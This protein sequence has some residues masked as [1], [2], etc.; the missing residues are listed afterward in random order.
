MTDDPASGRVFG[1]PYSFEV[2]TPR[3][4][5]SGHWR[6]GEGPLVEKPFGVGWTLNL[7]SPRTWLFLAVALAM[8]AVLARIPTDD[9][10]F[11]TDDPVEIDI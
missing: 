1:V 4:V 8:G 7:A 6:P 10:E 11:P 3:R 5:L 2:P 9:E